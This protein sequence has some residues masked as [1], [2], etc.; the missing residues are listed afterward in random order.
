MAY[1]L[2]TLVFM[3]QYDLFG[4]GVNEQRY[5]YDYASLLHYATLVG[6]TFYYM[7]GTKECSVTMNVLAQVRCQ[8]RSSNINAYSLDS[9]LCV[10]APDMHDNLQSIHGTAAGSAQRGKNHC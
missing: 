7:L 1:A 3:K 8:H 5:V 4:I 10:K 9:M 6:H 2:L